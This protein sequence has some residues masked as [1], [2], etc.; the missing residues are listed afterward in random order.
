M[1]C[2]WHKHKPNGGSEAFFYFFFPKYFSFFK[3]FGTFVSKIALQFISKFQCYIFSFILVHLFSSHTLVTRSH[4]EAQITNPS[5]PLSSSSVRSKLS[6]SF[7]QFNSLLT[8]LSFH[9]ITCICLITL[10][11]DLRLDS[12]FKEKRKTLKQVQIF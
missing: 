9:S 8:I 2:S 1:S 3:V 7:L 6:F 12:K 5:Q 11:R 4:R 10:Y